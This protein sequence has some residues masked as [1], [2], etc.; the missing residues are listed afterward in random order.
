MHFNILKNKCTDQIGIWN[1]GFWGWRKTREPREKPLEPGTR[2]NNK[3]NLHVTPGPGIEPRPQW[4]E[5]RAL[6]TVPFLH[7]TLVKCVQHNRQ[8]PLLKSSNNGQQ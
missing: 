6:T 3:L 2:T 1:V 4:W 5:A 7:P 8:L